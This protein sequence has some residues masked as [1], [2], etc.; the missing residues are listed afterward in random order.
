M[1]GGKPSHPTPRPTHDSLAFEVAVFVVP[2]ALDALMLCAD[3]VTT[4][5]RGKVWVSSWLIC[6]KGKDTHS[7][8]Y[9]QGHT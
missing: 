8:I 9:T 7:Q 1:C 6:G 2:S 5:E 4:E 3:S